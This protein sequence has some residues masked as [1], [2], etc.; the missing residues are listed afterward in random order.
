MQNRF[1]EWADV[2]VFLAVMREGSTLAAAR[3]LGVNQ[4]TV[5]RRVD[6][7]EHTLGLTLFEKTTRGA[8]PTAAAVELLEAAEAVEAAAHA[9]ESAAQTEVD[10][11]R[12]PIR[13]TA[14]DHSFMGNIGQI[15]ADYVEDNPGICFEFIASERTLD[16]VKGDADVALRLSPAITDDRLIARK[17]GDTT[18]TYYA[19]HDYAERHGT[20][21]AYCDDMGPHR[22]ALLNH[23][24]TKRRNVLRCANA[25]DLR[26]ALRSGLAVAP[27]PIF[28]GDADPDLV[29][30]FDPPPGSQMSIWLVTAPEAHKRPEVRRLTAHA[31]PLIK[32]NLKTVMT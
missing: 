1:K 7:L 32:R 12:P 6:V 4:T 14:F 31:A 8:A 27:L 16:L 25:S 18:W 29:R 24:V 21:G 17:I 23:V 3:V 10:R 28:D 11:A 26:Q 30:C 5:S 15:V 20:P 2:R 13:I 9:F 22:V 19:S